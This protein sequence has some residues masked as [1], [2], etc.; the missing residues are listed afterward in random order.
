VA[1]K[2]KK[3]APAGWSQAVVDG[4]ETDVLLELLFEAGVTVDRERF[5][6]VAATH[7]SADELA[8]ELDR[9]LRGADADL[10]TYAVHT[11]WGRWLP[12]RP[13]IERVERWIDEGYRE[14]R[15]ALPRWQR[16]WAALRPR[17]SPEATTLAAAQ[18]ALKLDVSLDHWTRS[19]VIAHEL[20]ALE[21]VDERLAWIDFLLGQ[22]RD[23]SAAWRCAL[24][25]CRVRALS[26]SGRRDEA[27]EEAR[28]MIASE[29]GEHAGFA[30]LAFLLEADGELEKT[31][32]ALERQQALLEQAIERLK[33]HGA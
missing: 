25:E 31:K 6:R 3:K 24:R 8:N 33:K 32:E 22:F 1:K 15:Q 21:R 27:Y 4:L 5:L 13:S 16:A 7:V 30:A 17:I 11:L 10:L 2:I 19:L 20:A 18:K 12:E 9:D 26:D 29:P 28:A 14:A 23:E